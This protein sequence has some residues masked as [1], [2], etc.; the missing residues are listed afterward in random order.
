[1]RIC[2]LLSLEKTRRDAPRECVDASVLACA[3]TI[4]RT[5]EHEHTVLLFG[6]RS[7]EDRA[8]ELG[9]ATHDR[10]PCPSNDPALAESSLARFLHDR[11]LFDS[12]T[13]W[14]LDTLALWNRC[15]WISLDAVGVLPGASRRATR[16]TIG[17]APVV[18]L[19]ERDASDLRSAGIDAALARVASSHPATHDERESLRR[20]LD[21]D[22]RTLL[23]GLLAEPP[24]AA[25]ALWMAYL[26]LVLEYRKINAVG[27]VPDGC[28]HWI[29]AKGVHRNMGLRSPLLRVDEPIARILPRCDIAVCHADDGSSLRGALSTQIERTLAAGVPVLGGPALASLAFYP[30]RARDA[31]IVGTT[32]QTIVTAKL[33]PLA[34][35]RV[36]RRRLRTLLIERDLQNTPPDIAE[37][38]ASLWAH[39]PARRRPMI[40]AK[41][42]PRPVTPQF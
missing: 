33:A 18:T 5:P 11:P 41:E 13:C 20:A 35:S 12:L 3:H 32:F 28:S 10:I 24:S 31:C 37:V 30:P 15:G 38:L 42:P 17:P 16:A 21:L 6:P 40:A 25:S 36:R 19:H 29:R 26:L 39:A 8:R 22:P 34:E 23:V 27:L 7:F 2:H 9:I 1:M 14:S 4:A